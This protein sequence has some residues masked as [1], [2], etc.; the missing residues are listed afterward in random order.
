MGDLDPKMVLVFV[1]SLSNHSKQSSLK[2]HTHSGCTTNVARKRV[3]VG[4]VFNHPHVPPSPRFPPFFLRLLGNF[5]AIV[6]LASILGAATE[7]MA[8]HTGQMAPAPGTG[9]VRG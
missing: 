2:K 7:A 1:V 9:G 6:P 5:V 8:A 4:W 3:E